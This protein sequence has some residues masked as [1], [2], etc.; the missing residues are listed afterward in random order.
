[1]PALVSGDTRHHF[2]LPFTAD[3]C[4]I[5]SLRG[6][7]A[8]QLATWGLSTLADDVT[9]AVSELATNVVCHVGPGTPAV[10]LLEVTGDRLRVEIHDTSRGLPTRRAAAEPGETG[11]GLALVAA[12]AGGWTATPTPGGKA[13]CCVFAVGNAHRVRFGA[14]IARAAGAIDGYRLSPSS[15]EIPLAVHP[16]AADALAVSLLTDLLHWAAANGSDP[17]DLL[18]HAQTCFETEVAETRAPT[19]LPPARTAPGA[20]TARAR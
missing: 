1:M 4:A 8:T 15:A 2:L 12:L 14:R 17:D 7:A 9:L 13:V 18:D 5:S 16:A 19:A 6:A 11:R 10:L 20:G 3:A